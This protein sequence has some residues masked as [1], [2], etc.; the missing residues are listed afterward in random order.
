MAE[1]LLINKLNFGDT[2]KNFTISFPK[3]KLIYFSG[4]NNC[5]KT[6]LLRTI[7]RKIYTKNKKTHADLDI[8]VR[9]E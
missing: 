3:E 6:T 7:D 5:G 9:T 2:L 8:C 1:L 4:K